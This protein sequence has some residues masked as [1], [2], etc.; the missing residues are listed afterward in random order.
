LQYTH[1]D[2]QPNANTG[3]DWDFNDNDNDPS[4]NLTSGVHGTACVGIV[5]SRGNNGLGVSGAA[6]EATLAGLRLI[7]APTTDTQE[8][9]AL[10][11]RN[12]VIY[13][14]SSSWETPDNGQTLAGPGPITAAALFR[15]APQVE[16]G[17]ARFTHGLAAMV[18]RNCEL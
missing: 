15:G 4:P 10:A 6:I 14:K 9:E 1:P 17:R 3:I 8:A 18:R 5:A 11:H 12:D 7:A 16:E 13:V 2:L